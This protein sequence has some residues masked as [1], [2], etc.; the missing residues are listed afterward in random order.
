MTGRAIHTTAK[1]DQ[2][3]HTVAAPSNVNDD[4]VQLFDEPPDEHSLQI[5][6]LRWLI[7]DVIR[8]TL[9]QRYDIPHDIR[10][11]L[12]INPQTDLDPSNIPAPEYQNVYE[13]AIDNERVHDAGL[14][15]ASENDDDGDDISPE[16]Q[17]INFNDTVRLY[18]REIGNIKLINSHHEQLYARAIEAERYM[19]KYVANSES[20]FADIN[21]LRLHDVVEFI[22]TIARQSLQIRQQFVETISTQMIDD[23]RRII[24]QY[25]A[26]QSDS[27]RQ[28]TDNTEAPNELGNITEIDALDMLT[29]LPKDETSIKAVIAYWKKQ[30][31]RGRQAREYLT[32]ANLRLVVSVAKRYIGRGLQLLDLIQEGNVGLIRAVEKFDHRRGFKFS[33]YATWWIRQAITRAIADQARTIRIPVHMVETINK[34]M[35]ETRRLIQEKGRD[36]N[37][38][39]LAEVMG[40]TVDR[41]RVIRKTS[42]EPISLETPVGIEED[43]HLGDFIE[44][45][46]AQA[47]ADVATNHLLREQL[48]EVLSR[49]NERER[50]VLQLRF[51]LEDGHNWTLEEV[52]RELNVTRERI[53]QIEVKALRKLRSSRY[54]LDYM[55]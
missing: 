14:H 41:I 39:E 4:D 6:T 47:P 18:L 54:L 8:T 19:S 46:K 5:D 1:D 31:I 44:D 11:Q 50:R 25:V 45:V 43:S 52:G 30:I 22:D 3:A 40:L 20:K 29:E 37:D 27:N 7:P 36:P 26:K 15:D 9:I 48:H 21:P 35:R 10:S 53:R 13:T 38:E 51:G 34:L 24:T 12:D 55:E 33:T 28:S 17:S 49:L 42:L 32:S 16:L 2:T 23:C